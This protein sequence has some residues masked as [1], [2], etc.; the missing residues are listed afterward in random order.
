MSSVFSRKIT[1]STSCGAFTGEGTPLNQRT[2]RRQA[3]RSSFCRSATLSERNPPPTGVVSGPLIATRWRSMAAMVSSGSQ[4]LSRSLAF[5]PA[6]TSIH[7]MRRLP[8]YARS[9]AASNT[10][11]EARQMSGPVPSPSMKGMIGVAG[12]WS[13]PSFMVMG[14]PSVGALGAGDVGAVAGM[15]RDPSRGCCHEEDRC[16]RRSI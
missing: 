3:Y 13:R 15:G 10:R 2:G 16:D 1:M 6:S 9:T 14:C 5:S 12:T 4:L 8:A 11:T 7:A